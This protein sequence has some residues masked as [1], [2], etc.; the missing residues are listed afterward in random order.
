MDKMGNLPDWQDHD[1]IEL[2]KKAQSGEADAFGEL[3]ERYSQAIFRFLFSHVDNR[4]DA[5]DLTEEVFLKVWRSLSSYRDQGVPFL[6][7]LFKI[8]RNTMIDHY[9]RAGKKEQSLSIEETSL[10]HKG[11][12]PGEEAISNLEHAEIRQVLNQLRDD[13]RMVLIL[14]FIS[15]LT[16]EET[17][18]TMGR[19]AGAVRV[20]QHRAI[21]A[22]RDL[23]EVR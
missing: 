15:D 3:Y 16:P 14:R 2:L 9:R 5:E 8:A 11:T 18:H 13:Y 20:L 10:Q 12:D 4:L 17:A 1:D 6:A 23:L 22:A 21:N 7:F 19:T